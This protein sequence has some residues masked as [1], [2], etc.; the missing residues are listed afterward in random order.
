[1][2]TTLSPHEQRNQLFPSQSGYA[3][4]IQDPFPVAGANGPSQT[5]RSIQ[6][7]GIQPS[8]KTVEHGHVPFGYEN[9]DPLF[10][11]ARAPYNQGYTMSHNYLTHSNSHF[12]PTP[13]LSTF[14]NS[15]FD[16]S[17][18]GGQASIQRGS[19]TPHR[20]QFGTDTNFESH[21]FVAPPEQETPQ[22]LVQR[23][24][25][26][27]ECLKPEPSPANTNPSSPILQK[28]NRPAPA[29]TAA[30]YQ[31]KLQPPSPPHPT[32]DIE[33][34]PPSPSSSVPKRRKR[35]K[36]GSDSDPDFSTT[37][38]PT[39][40]PSKRVKTST[41]KPS[42]SKRKAAPTPHSPSADNS[43]PQLRPSSAKPNRAHL[44]EEQKKTNHIIS[45]QKR[46]DL[47]K[48]GYDGIKEMVPELKDLKYS[49]G[50]MLEAAA[51]WLEDIVHC[52]GALRAQLENT[53]SGY[54]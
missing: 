29:M 3:N 19:Q 26:H 54:G 25:N 52:N 33:P 18:L 36:S 8:G 51:N 37:R 20:L 30:S 16:Q 46:R 31:P 35:R 4:G 42:S 6:Y 23:K 49:K 14:A 41:T 53:N 24:M 47:I 9:I 21:S 5:Q 10:A 50:A 27:M 34:E 2:S 22:N 15:Y 39:R 11:H 28:K 1:M 13:P 40:Q 32:H 45:E 43:T 38:K 48:R 17:S 44:T 12:F 7:N